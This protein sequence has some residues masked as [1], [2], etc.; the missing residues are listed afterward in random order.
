MDPSE[1]EHA[2]REDEHDEESPA[3]PDEEVPP[4]EEGEELVQGVAGL[5]YG[6]EDTDEGGAG[7]DEEGAH[8]G[9]FGEGLAEDDG[10][11]DGIEDE[12]GLMGGAVS[13]CL[14]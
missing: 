12:A 1:E 7:G 9:V 10:C 14:E 4:A 6:A 5:G 3:E 11:A 8:E 2:H 13:V